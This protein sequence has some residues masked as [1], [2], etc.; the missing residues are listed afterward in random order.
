[1]EIPRHVYVVKANGAHIGFKNS[2]FGF[3]HKHQAQRVTSFLDRTSPD[4]F[5]THVRSNQ[6]RM[7]RT[8]HISPARYEICKYE[9]DEYMQHIIGN[10]VSLRVV[11]NV[12]LQEDLPEI[13]IICPLKIDPVEDADPMFLEATYN[14][15]FRE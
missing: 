11:E 15:S 1:M 8:R 4:I 9:N 13:L 3:C 12:D 6:F 2:V 7:T 10:H 14:L 5:Y